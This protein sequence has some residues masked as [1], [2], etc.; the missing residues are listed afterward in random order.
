MGLRRK[1]G[2]VVCVSVV[3][4][5]LLFPSPAISY[6]SA[7]FL[8]DTGAWIDTLSLAACPCLSPAARSCMLSLPPLKRVAS[9]HPGSQS[10]MKP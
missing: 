7:N 3:E 4:V 8:I 1:R 5:L 10:A 9:S 2:V 6:P